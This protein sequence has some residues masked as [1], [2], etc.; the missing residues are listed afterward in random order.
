MP[1]QAIAQSTEQGYSYTMSTIRLLALDMDDTLLR[2]DLT[3]SYRTRNVIKR[4][5]SA[6]TV[7]TLAT[8]RVPSVMERFIKLLGLNKKSGYL[9]SNNGAL[10]QE[11]DTGK[12]IHEARLEPEIAR[13]IC[14]LADAE[15]FPVQ[16]YEDDVM[17][18]SRENEFSAYDQRLTGLRQVVV[19][20]FREM[21]G[22]GCHKLFIPGD[23]MLLEPL[24]DILHAYLEHDITLFSG[25]KY[26]LEILPKDTNKGNAL[27][28]IAESLG[29]NSE[30]T[31]AIGDSI[32]DEAMIKWAGLGVA[33]ING[34]EHIKSIA[35]IITENSN[36]D[37]GVADIIDKYILGKDG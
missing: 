30:E 4:A 17:Y 37:D 5:E 18:V 12:I 8:S 22:K 26:F 15:G 9:I 29:I 6:G 1:I 7:I 36:D 34:D 24:E 19:D 3:I 32:N 14:D 27:A 25:K 11:S 2:S 21:I 33:M 35:N 28:K 23:P 13:I 10:I 31:I 20:N 16:L